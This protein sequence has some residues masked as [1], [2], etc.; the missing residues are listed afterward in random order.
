[1]KQLTC[2]V[3]AGVVGLSFV[4]GFLARDVLTTQCFAQPAIE[5]PAT[6]APPAKIKNAAPTKGMEK[7]ME[8]EP[9]K[10]KHEVGHYQL[11]LASDKLYI[12]DT[13]N[14][15]C[16]VRE[17]KPANAANQ[18]AENWIEISPAWA[19]A[20]FAPAGLKAPKPE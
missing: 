18:N 3:G 4:S 2:F 14:A 1:M 7:G 12:L 17:A 20:G 9:G 16:W 15:R 11:A 10:Q 5:P 6:E 13:T 19:S 8:K